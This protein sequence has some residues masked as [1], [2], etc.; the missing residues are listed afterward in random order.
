[1]D[2]DVESSMNSTGGV[3]D[4]E[5]PVQLIEWEKLLDIYPEVEVSG[6]RGLVIKTTSNNSSLARI[7]YYKEM[8]KKYEEPLIIIGRGFHDVLHCPVYRLATSRGKPLRWWFTPEMFAI[9]GESPLRLIR[10][11]RKISIN[12]H[13]LDKLI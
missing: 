1:M 4:F 10:D 13:S 2:S 8:Y 3:L 9:Q 5:T 7:V 11:Q 12:R 6:E